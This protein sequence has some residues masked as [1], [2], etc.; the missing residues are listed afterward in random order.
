MQLNSRKQDNVDMQSYGID[1]EK[2]PRHI[3]IIMDG[4]G[5]W[6]K[7]RGLSRS[8]GH[9][10]GV[11]ALRAVVKECSLLGVAVLT[12]YAFS[13]ENWRRP[14]EEVGL[15]MALLIEYL[16]KEIDELHRNDIMIR[17]IGR[18]QR[19]PLEVQK[20]LEKAIECTKSNKGLILN[21][22]LNYGGRADIVEAV[23]KLSTEVLNKNIAPEDINEVIVDNALY[24]AGLPDPDLLIRTSGE[25]RLSNFLL[26]QIAY[27][28]IVVVEDFWPDFNQSRLHEAIR[29]FQKRDRRYGGLTKS[30]E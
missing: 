16:K 4:N 13:T 29:N 7:R 15:L 20:E 10:A 11:E 21:V 22:A 23:R 26:W 25:M 12:V 3:A 6:A 5:R 17:T 9:R 28:E 27:T 19:L 8:M 24:T 1:P 14:K 30:K 2:L 18:T